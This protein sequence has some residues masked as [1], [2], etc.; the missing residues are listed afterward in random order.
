MSRQADL[1]D[2]LKN[3]STERQTPDTLDIDLLDSLGYS[4]KTADK[5][6]AVIIGQFKPRQSKH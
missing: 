4:K 6:V 5:K 2:A 3:I 1:V